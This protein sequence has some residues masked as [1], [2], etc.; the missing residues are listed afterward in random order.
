[1]DGSWMLLPCR[2]VGR[3][4]NVDDG[5]EEGGLTPPRTA[6]ILP[7]AFLQAWFVPG[8]SFSLNSKAMQKR[9]FTVREAN[10]LLPFLSSGVRDLRQIHQEL[11]AA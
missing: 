4:K 2:R 1:M 5:L 7:Q 10:E 8:P 9:L 6:R 11:S 3:L